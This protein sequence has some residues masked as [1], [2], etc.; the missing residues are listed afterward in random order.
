MNYCST[1]DGLLNQPTL[2]PKLTMKKNVFTEE[3]NI[4]SKKFKKFTEKN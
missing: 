1:T 3:L 2:Q 4:K